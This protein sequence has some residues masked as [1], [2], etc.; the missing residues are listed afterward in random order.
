M[1]GLFGLGNIQIGF[2]VV[3]GFQRFWVFKLL[4]LGLKGLIGLVYKSGIGLTRPNP[5]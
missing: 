3:F 5:E 2:W 4:G 1:F